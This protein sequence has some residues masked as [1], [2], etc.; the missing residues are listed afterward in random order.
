MATPNVR[1]HIKTT[2]VKHLGIDL[3]KQMTWRNH[4]WMK[5]KQMDTKFRKNNWFLRIKSLLSMGYKLLV[6]NIVLKA[7]WKYDLQLWGTISKPKVAIM[8]RFQTMVL[9][10]ITNAP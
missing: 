6:Y 1:L 8:G 5:R 4:I 10:A 3:D 7:A 2:S 9:R